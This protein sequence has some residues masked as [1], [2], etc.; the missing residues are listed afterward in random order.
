MPRHA[1]IVENKKQQRPTTPTLRRATMP[2]AVKNLAMLF[3]GAR[4]QKATTTCHPPTS[5]TSDTNFWRPLT[6]CCRLRGRA[7]ADGTARPR[8]PHTQHVPSKKKK[9]NNNNNNRER[10]RDVVPHRNVGTTHTLR[11]APSVENN[12][13]QQQPTT[14]TPRRATMPH[15]GLKVLAMLFRRARTRQAPPVCHPQTSGTNVIAATHSLLWFER[16]RN[17]NRTRRPTRPT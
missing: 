16:A 3:R 6:R 14:P 17:R 13:K 9:R 15:G 1:P 2:T 11:H 8:A 4:T 5:D 12:K 7:P 10:L